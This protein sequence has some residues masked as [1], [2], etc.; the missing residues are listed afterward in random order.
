MPYLSNVWSL[1]EAITW[2]AFRR[3]N[4][5]F[6]ER[7]AFDLNSAR[8]SPSQRKLERALREVLQ[9][10]S[11]GVLPI[12]ARRVRDDRTCIIPSVEVDGLEF[13]VA[14]DLP[15]RPCGFRNASNHVLEWAEPRISARD[16]T[17]NWPAKA[18]SVRSEF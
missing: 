9:T 16:V 3:P 5:F 15:S 8:M 11:K 1:T 7:S 13:Y 12:Q 17:A 18:R 2:V 14:T 10:A 4:A 6:D